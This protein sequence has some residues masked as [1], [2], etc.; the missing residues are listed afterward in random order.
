MD[1][2]NFQNSP[3]S[4]LTIRIILLAGLV[5]LPFVGFYFGTKYE[6]LRV[7]V[8]NSRVIRLE[9][10]DNEAPSTTTYETTTYHSPLGISFRYASKYPNGG[11]TDEVLVKEMGNVIYVYD[12]SISTTPKD[13]QSITVYKK[14]QNESLE[15]SINR[16]IIRNTP[17]CRVVTESDPK[18]YPPTYVRADISPLSTEGIIDADGLLRRC[19][20]TTGAGG[21][22][23]FLYDANH[24]DK[25][26]FLLIG[27]DVLPAND[28]ASW[29]DT[30][31][32]E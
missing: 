1:I 2:N 5:F 10:T 21:I 4:Y 32:F 27:Q 13:G 11:K 30:L 25:F 3:K 24:P 26:V 23:F 28:S 6:S 19:S 20:L 31:I 14:D 8:D 22:S 9:R 17:G 15:E 18:G 12:S 7:A 16:Q 29:Q